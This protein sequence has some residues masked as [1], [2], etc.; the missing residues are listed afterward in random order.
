VSF[1]LDS[2]VTLSWYF[3]D[4]RTEATIALLRRVAGSGA[5]VP[6]LWRLEVANGLQVAVRRGRIDTAY[7][8]ASLQDLGSF[9]I[10]VDTETDRHAWA[11]TLQLSDRLRLTLYD[12][13][14]L[15]LAL[16][17]QLPLA[18]LDGGLAKAAFDEGVLV[19]G[20]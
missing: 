17:L 2:S 19:L 7:R 8:N 13:S 18:T 5:T 9:A 16:R 3:D 12:A 15:E 10:V 14:Y 20:C 1:V 11:A 6:S 4:E